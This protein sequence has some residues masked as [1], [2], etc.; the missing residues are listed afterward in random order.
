MITMV[1]KKFLFS[2]YQSKYDSYVMLSNGEISQC[3]PK[4]WLFNIFKP[5]GRILSI[6]MALIHCDLSTKSLLF[7][8]LFW[9]YVH[10]EHVKSFFRKNWHANLKTLAKKENPEDWKMFISS[11]NS[12][13]M[14]LKTEFIKAVTKLKIIRKTRNRI[15]LKR[16]LLC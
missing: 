6:R 8:P 13:N 11:K 14:N 2:K 10:H 3:F 12:L 1:L 9:L 15:H 5:E 7:D 4:S 16:V